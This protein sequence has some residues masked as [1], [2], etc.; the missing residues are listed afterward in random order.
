MK[1]YI[2]ILLIAAGV[3]ACTDPLKS[4]VKFKAEVMT[5]DTVTVDAE[6][7][8][9]APVGTSV[10]F[11]FDSN[12]DFISLNYSVFNE[13]NAILTWSNKV[14]WAGNDDNLHLYLSESWPGW[15]GDP[16][17]DSV[18]VRQHPW[19]DL[20]ATATWPKKQN[21]TCLDTIDLT[22]WRGKQVVLAWQY[23]TRENST[24]Q[25]MFTIS[26]LQI[27]NTVIKNGE[28][29]S[30]TIAQ[31]MGW[32]PFDMMLKDSTT[33]ES[34]NKN[35]RWDVSFSDTNDKTAIKI[36]QTSKNGELNEDWLTSR[37]LTIPLGKE[38]NHPGIAI[39]NIYLDVPNYTFTF[40]EFGEFTLT[41]HATNA[42]YQ[43]ESSTKQTFKFVIYE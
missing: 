11:I 13:T 1:K 38:V 43:Q 15:S 8:F 21:E 36:R 30:A 40:E 3:T 37:M 33:Y 41:F 9:H 20:G 10:Q 14:T 28:Q 16:D 19:I 34:S 29:A 31:N 27:T 5:N 35:G 6:G 18:M 2:Y 7:V 17:A 12:A 26:N 39:K 23:V 4:P 32:I 25:P 42:N 22:P 24:I